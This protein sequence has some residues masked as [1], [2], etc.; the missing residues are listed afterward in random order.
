M[1]KQ[2]FQPRQPYA[3]NRAKR[4]RK[5]VYNTRLPVWIAR[6]P[7]V[8]KFRRMSKKRRVL[9]VGWSV[10]SVL[11]I[12][13]LA[14]TVYFANSLGSKERIMNR[15]K[16][17]L[18]LVDQAGQPFYRFYNAH[19]STYVTLDKIAP[20]AKQAA[21]A[22]EDKNFYE[23]SGFS[24][25]GVANAVYQ[26]L[27]PGGLDNGGST[28]TQQLVKN[29]LLSQQ[30]SFVRKYQ[31][32]VLSIE[33]ERR[34]SKDEILEMYLNSVYFGEGAFGIENAAQTYFGTSA[35][36][37]DL[38]Q[39]SMLIGLLP[40]PSAYSPISGDSAKA[41]TRQTYVLGRMGEDMLIESAAQIAAL[42]QPLSYAPPKTEEQQR[43]PHFALMVKEELE[44][45]Y[46]EER[47]ARSG[48]VVKTSLNL[49]WQT[50][51]E[52]AVANQVSRLANNNV[53]N[54]S[55]VVIDP[56]TGEIRA[57]VGSKDWN[58]DVFGKFNIATSKNRQPGS[59]FKP[60]VYAS[61]IEARTFSAATIF[62]DQA[63]DFGGGYMP[64][65]YDLR[66]RGDVTLRRALANSL[67][68]PAVDALKQV[69]IENTAE[70]ARKLGVSTLDNGDSL[71]LSLALGTA[72]IPLVEMTNAYAVLAN[73]GQFNRYTTVSQITNKDG[74]Q[75]FIHRAENKRAIS[76]QTS[77]IISSILSDNRA[78]SESFGDSLTLR[79]RT[80]AIKTG[81]TEDYRDALAIGYTP[82]IA[83]GVWIGNN[84][85]TPMTRIAGSSGA[86]PIWSTIMQQILGAT[87]NEQFTVPV[88]LTSRS[89]CR[90]NGAL[91]QSGGTNTLTEYFLPGTLPKTTCNQP[92]ATTKPTAA[93][94]QT[95]EI[96]QQ[97][98]LTPQSQSTDGTN[99]DTGQAG[100]QDQT[101]QAAAIP[102]SSQ[103]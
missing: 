46:G 18:T 55:V 8:Q 91:A 99:S 43:A 21:L 66:Y 37:L 19:S 59:S 3:R 86:A 36:N 67:N 34:Y 52:N 24:V 71:N 49:G 13:A 25:K 17:G 85:N 84:D 42:N 95:P 22:S 83:V 101:P 2:S 11:I 26:N 6:I 87:V 82:S 62:K 27:R 28:I 79:N 39:A 23:H 97:Y 50:I 32:L 35:A 15:N 10:G 92:A 1:S 56:K 40:A 65:N 61:G 88:G 5:S 96:T 51:A 94:N 98:R 75:I 93:P 41:K 4:A 47:I 58:N 70:T 38:A 63:T 89:V 54:G 69:G 16:T 78:R 14:T 81:T 57:L 33:I 72:P 100:N 102:G 12:T 77:Y 31:E 30:R 45:K 64:K 90:A 7:I 48:Y 80:A 44:A 103:P 20:V 9:L 73:A 29:A 68:I 53:T 74:K 60:L 76:P